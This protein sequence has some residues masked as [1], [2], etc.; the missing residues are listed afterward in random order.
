MSATL[1]LGPAIRS[2]LSFCRIE[3]GLA[4]NS[5]ESY[6]RDLSRF[7]TWISVSGQAPELASTVR[8]Y[9]DHLM[10]EGLAARSIARH[11]TALR[12]L[13]R[14]LISEN[15]LSQDPAALIPLPRQWKTLPKALSSSQMGSLSDSPP[16]ATPLGLRDRAMIELLYS[17]GLR[18]TELCTLETSDLL[19]DRGIVR[20]TGKGNK[21]RLVPVGQAALQAIR[22]YVGQ[23]RPALL[24]G[25]ASRYLFISARGGGLDRTAFFRAI[26]NHGLRAGLSVSPHKLR[27]TFATHLL[28][29]GAD[30]R[31]VQTMLGHADISTTQVYTHVLRS[32]LKQTL[33]KHH[34]RA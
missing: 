5:M 8:A 19:D 16:V 24:K 17:S 33:E 10:A 23:A 30:L 26:R 25:R 2:F 34:P 1:A 31:S 11:L 14:Y 15:R 6:A 28:E 18:V 4:R 13:Y 12:Q 22:V 9:L 3:K 21:Q 27:H 7:E 20:V 32:R 29:G